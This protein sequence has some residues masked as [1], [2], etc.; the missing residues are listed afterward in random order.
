MTIAKID[1]PD[2]QHYFDSVAKELDGMRAE[3]DVVAMAIGSQIAA[4]WLPL[5]GISYDPKGDVLAIAVEGLD[6]LVRK[7]DTIFVDVEQGRLTSMDVTD[8]EQVRHIV[9]LRGPQAPS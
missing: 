9:K 6:H 7:P 3:I 4:E 5:L 2:W 1:K 8:S